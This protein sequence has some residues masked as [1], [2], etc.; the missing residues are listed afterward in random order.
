MEN[1]V[2]KL[3]IQ[4]TTMY[5]LYIMCIYSI[6]KGDTRNM[7]IAISNS[8]DKPIYDQI[9]LQIKN[10]IISGELQAGEA[11]PSLRFLAK[12][13]KV[14]VIST[15]R[16]YEELEREGYIESVPGK[17]SFVAQKNAKLIR[18][19][20]FRRAEAHLSDAIEVA[21]VSGI[22]LE[23]LQEMMTTLYES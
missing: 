12:E 16:A 3:N 20:Q 14:S 19:E 11:L 21:R 23:E 2:K 1:L 17:G 5:I 10:A 18:E 13:L 6:T 4:L 15:K 22:T 8:S 9:T 7:H